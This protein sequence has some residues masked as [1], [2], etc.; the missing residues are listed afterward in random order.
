[1][2]VKGV[3]G[4]EDLITE[5]HRKTERKQSQAIFIYLSLFIYFWCT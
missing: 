2:R 5:S 3:S 4:G 1:M